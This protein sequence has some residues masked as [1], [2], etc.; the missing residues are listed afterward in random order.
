MLLADSSPGR[1]AALAAAALTAATLAD[2]ED[3]LLAAG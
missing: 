2:E 3:V 1:A